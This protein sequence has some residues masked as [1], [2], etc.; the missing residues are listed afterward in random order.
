MGV[1]AEFRAPEEC[2]EQCKGLRRVRLEVYLAIEDSLA[3]RAEVARDS[4]ADEEGVAIGR[5]DNSGQDFTRKL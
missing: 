2:H 3:V 5:P 4:R 1:R